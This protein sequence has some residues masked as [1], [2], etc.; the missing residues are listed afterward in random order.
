MW[1]QNNSSASYCTHS[2]FRLRKSFGSGSGSKYGTE[3][4][5]YLA[6]VFNN[7]KIRTKS[8]LLMLEAALFPKK[9]FIS[10]LI[11]LLLYSSLCWTWTKIRIWFRLDN[12][13]F[14][15]WFRS[16]NTQVP[17]LAE[18]GSEWIPFEF[19][20]FSVSDT[21]P[22]IRNADADPDHWTKVNVDNFR[23]V[24]FSGIFLC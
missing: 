9:V 6:L 17:L 1:S 4:R 10:Y 7:N 20:C 14:F 8:C 15:L 18:C 2:Q 16:H 5:P 21:W 22:E 13:M 23:K 3:F 12:K 19:I 11:F 24:L